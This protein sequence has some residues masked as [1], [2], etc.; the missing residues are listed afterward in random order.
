MRYALAFKGISY[1]SNFRWGNDHTGYKISPTK[2]FSDTWPFYKKCIVDPIRKKGDAIDIFFNT[3][4][5]EKI[6]EYIEEMKPAAIRLKEF[7]TTLKQNDLENIWRIKRDALK[8]VRDY[9]EENKIKYDLVFVAR[10]DYIIIQKVTEL[11]Y[12]DDAMSFGS[13]GDPD[14]IAVPGHM[15]DRIIEEYTKFVH[16]Q[17]PWGQGLPPHWFPEKLTGAGVKIHCLYG[18]AKHMAVHHAGP[19]MPFV[20]AYPGHPAVAEPP[21]SYYG[22]EGWQ[23]KY[24]NDCFYNESSPYYYKQSHWNEEGGWLNN[25]VYTPGWVKDTPCPDYDCRCKEG[26]VPDLNGECET[27]EAKP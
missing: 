26:E 20:R 11:F 21:P 19:C 15:L 24:F 17:S 16:W 18:S 3:Y 22:T 27:R 13:M 25:K 7:N 10:F 6:D 4:H 5:S 8:L 14:F 23:D 1:N 12:P 9:G 2:D